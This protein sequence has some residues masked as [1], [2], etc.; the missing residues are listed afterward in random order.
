MRFLATADL[1]IKEL[2]EVALLERILDCAKARCCEAVLIGGDLLDHPFPDG[3][4]EQALLTLLGGAGLPILLVA[5]NH[6]P[7]ELTDL[8]NK[9]PKGCYCFPAAITAVSLGELRVFGY[10]APRRFGEEHPLAGWQAPQGG[11]N[12][13]LAHGHVDGSDFLPIT[14]AELAESG[15]Q[16][17]IVGHIH[18]GE[19]RDIGGCRLLVP[20]I[21]EGR[22]WDELGEKFV[23]I[24]D[25]APNGAVSFEAVSVAERCYR[26]LSV[27]VSGCTEEEVLA[28]LEA[29]EISAD[30]VARLILVGSPA[31]DPAPAARLYT[32][33]HGRE[34]VDRTD[35]SLSV[36]VLKEQKTL[37]GAF[38]RRALAEIE[39]ADPADRPILEE[40]LRLG[41]QALKEARV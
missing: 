17:A 18:K 21:P 15:L 11:V 36:A 39:A 8:Y 40:A 37:Q 23:Y 41:L 20:G 12:I 7:L 5:G 4:V 2:S 33:R 34:T 16:L 28:R 10:S 19:R 3:A 24:V 38:V 6:D 1:H 35:P 31:C 27:E 26:E 32:E 14:S 29:V 13:L 25:A 9:L 30:T 22:G